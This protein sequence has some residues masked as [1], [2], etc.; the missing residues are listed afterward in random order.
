MSPAS[1]DGLVEAVAEPEGGQPPSPF[2]EQ[3]VG[4]LAVAGVDQ[5]SLRSAQGHPGVEVGQ[6]RL[7]E[8]D[9][10]FGA[11]L[12][13]RDLDPGAAVTEVPQAVELEVEKLAES[14]PGA[15]QDGQAVA[16]ERIRRA[17]PRRP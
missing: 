5:R 13:Q 17:R 16:G 6:S 3:E 10:P 4:G 15:A 14:H 9:G 12:A 7:V 11:E 2:D 1:A 8:W